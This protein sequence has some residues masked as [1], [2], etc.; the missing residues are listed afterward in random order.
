[1]RGVAAAALALFVGLSTFVWCWPAFAQP[2]PT[3]VVIDAGDAELTRQIK[4]EAVH[5]GFEVV[6]AEPATATLRVMSKDEVEI[7]IGGQRAPSN[8]SRRAG[9]GGSFAVRVAEETRARLIELSLWPGPDPIAEPARAS[10]ATEPPPAP[11]APASEPPPMT[12]SPPYDPGVEPKRRQLLSSLW[13]AGGGA[14][15]APV[16]GVGPTAH[17]LLGVGIE[18]VPNEWGLNA[19][20]LLPLTENDVEE[21]EGE[22]DVTV[23]AFVLELDRFAPLGS[24]WFVSGGAGGGLLVLSMRVEASDPFVP[25][26][27][28]LVTGVY[29]LHIGAGAALASWLRLRASL[30]GGLAAPRP[31]LRFDDHDVAAWGRGFV[32]LALRAELGVPLGGAAW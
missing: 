28:S 27:D 29:Y 13:I 32:A 25:R 5:V 3:L 11:T 19:A 6:P 31:V 2:K 4:A 30:L 22:A 18:L 10:N 9:E 15:M 8:L 1:L 7:G 17:G 23:S 26:D 24:S 20:A 16:G 14:A 12:R 21:P